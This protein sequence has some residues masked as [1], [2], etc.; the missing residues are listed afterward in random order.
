MSLVERAAKRLEELARARSQLP[1]RNPYPPDLDNSA[2][3][4]LERDSS[5]E[6]PGPEAEEPSCA[7]EGNARNPSSED[8]L[9]AMRSRPRPVAEGQA[10]TT[11]LRAD[12]PLYEAPFTPVTT[13]K[14]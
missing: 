6:K 11:S 4:V 10:D 2:P 12:A 7:T 5:N 9:R 1:R 13:A 14:P 8:I 3:D